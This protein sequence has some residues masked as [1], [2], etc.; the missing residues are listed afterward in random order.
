MNVIQAIILGLIQGLTEFIPV[1]SS[2]HLILAHYF[3][4]INATGLAF[5]VALHLGTLTAL[6]IYFYKDLVQLGK[7]LFVKNEHTRLAWLLIAATLPAVVVGVLLE[8]AAESAFRSPR[9]VAFDMTV[10]AV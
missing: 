2:G 7:G 10:A 8:K 6:L 1:S 4:G 9:L 5:D 3:F